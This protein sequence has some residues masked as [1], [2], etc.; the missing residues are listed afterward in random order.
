MPAGLGRGLRSLWVRLCLG[1]PIL[2]AV[3]GT[4]PVA[5]LAQAD[6]SD[7]WVRRARAETAAL[8]RILDRMDAQ[9]LN[10]H[11][12]LVM[13]SGALAA[14]RYYAGKDQA[15]YSLWRSRRT[16]GAADLHDMRSVSKSVIGLVYGILLARGEV[17]SLAT[18]V[19]SL[20]PDCPLREASA[21]PAVRIRDLLTMTAGLAWDEPSPVQ[22]A[23]WDD[24]LA[25]TWTG[26]VYAHLFSRER[27]AEP[28]TRFVY[29]GGATAVL[30]DVMERATRRPLAE[31]V[32]RELFEPM[33][34]AEWSWTQ[35]LR[36]RALAFAG[37]RLRPRD[38]LKLGML[39]LDKGRWQGRQLVPAAWIEAATAAQ[40]KASPDYGY[41]YQWWVRTHA[42]GGRTV[43]VVQAIGNGG[44]RLYVVPALQLVVAMT[45]G[46]YGTL[47]ILA[48]EDTLFLELAAGV[49]S[50]P[51]D[52]TASR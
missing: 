50:A 22:R 43:R 38:L 35:D 4:P 29:S 27:V 18:P 45:A 40:V 33:G 20:Y 32:A 46:D 17:P 16:F 37:L 12:V 34:I 15:I 47:G 2:A 48:D 5:A 7:A 42:I 28:G 49:V 24:Q 23:A 10:V 25:L 1:L 11:S 30:A 6:A 19:A 14:E 31:L 51:V 21:V 36:G 8:E 41:G 13:Q 44:Q 26:S 52:D 39:V 3:A 9:A